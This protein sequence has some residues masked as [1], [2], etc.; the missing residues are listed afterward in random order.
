[1]REILRAHCPDY[2]GARDA[3]I[4]FGEGGPRD[5][6]PVVG[7]RWWSD[8][9]V[10]PAPPWRPRATR[11]S[12]AGPRTSRAAPTTRFATGARASACSTTRRSRRAP[13]RPTPGSRAWPSSTATCTRATA[14]RRSCAATTP[15]SRSRSTARATSPSRRRRATSTSSWPTARATRTY[16]QQPRARAGGDA[17]AL[18]AAARDLPRGRGSLRGGSP[19]PPQAHEGGAR[20]PGRTRASGA[21][22]PGGI[23]V[24][25]A[26]AGGYGRDIDDTV[27]IHAATIH[28]ARRILG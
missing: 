25:I 18:A 3:G 27:A 26:M 4:A 2:L 6:L 22:S 11:S 28:A 23:P 7:R 9:A 16:L 14:R 13:S 15:C 1:M 5:R 24:A 12:R 17:R 21:F 20:A 10:P 19:G 8:R